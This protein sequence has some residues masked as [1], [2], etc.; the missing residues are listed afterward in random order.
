MPQVVWEAHSL[1][2][3]GAQFAK[4][5]VRITSGET[6]NVGIAAAL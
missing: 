3:W 2:N 6:G 1:Q 4:A 5:G